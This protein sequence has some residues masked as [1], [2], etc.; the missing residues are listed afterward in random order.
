LIQADIYNLPFK[1]GAFD[2][3]YCLGVLHHLPNIK[4]AF[5]KMVDLTRRNGAILVYLYEDFSDRG[6]LLRIL[7]HMVNFLRFAVSGM[8]TRILYLLCVIFSP[9]VWI[10][11]SLPSFILKNLGLNSISR[12]LPFRH[13]LNLNC[14]V[15]DLYDRFSPPIENRYSQQQVK[16][17]FKEFNLNN[18]FT[19]KYRGWVALGVKQNGT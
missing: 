6:A 15:S 1:E 14:I 10:F 4:K 17:L 3:I 8:N 11:F 12:R 16:S 9:L 5:E 2:L 19:L 13:T 18:I 7:L